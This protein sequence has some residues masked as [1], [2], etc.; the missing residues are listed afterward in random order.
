MGDLSHVLVLP[1][2]GLR[3]APLPDVLGRQALVRPA[4][5]G[6]AALSAVVI[7]FAAYLLVA[8]PRGQVEASAYGAIHTNG[9]CSEA[10]Q[11]ENATAVAR[12]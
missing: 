4:L 6:L 3:S 7:T 5:V 2:S 11:H 8:Q 12:R 1:R 9:G 10:V